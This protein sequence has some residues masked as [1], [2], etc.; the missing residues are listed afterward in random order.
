MASA[1]GQ[2]ESSG[3]GD[4]T[5]SSGPMFAS[6]F[7]LSRISYGEVRALGNAAKAVYVNFNNGP[8][9]LQTPWLVTPFGVREP[10]P[11]YRDANRRKF[12]I[13]VNLTS[14]A[15]GKDE[16]RQFTEKMIE[17]DNKLIDDAVANSADWLRKKKMTREVCDA[18]FTRGVRIA[19]D[20]DTQEPTDKYPPNFKIK[21]PYYEDAFACDLFNSNHELVSTPIDE[22]ISGRTDVRMLIKCVGLW[23]AGG[24]FGCSWKAEAI[25]YKESR[26]AGV[27][28]GNYSFLTDGSEQTDS[29]VVA[30]AASAG[31]T[32]A[33]AADDEDIVDEDEDIV[34]DSDIES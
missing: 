9:M 5:A 24:K 14:G 17:F 19:K 20:R 11:E 4:L 21:V 15:G 1:S 29:I 13:D 2:S 18:L 27:V 6:D 8:V 32:A 3:A 16:I 23:F 30:P 26:A 25:E 10:P 12:S 31:G 22:V 7:D 28:R 33:A 34:E